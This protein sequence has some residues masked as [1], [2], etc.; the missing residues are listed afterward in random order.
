M[1]Y[2]SLTVQADLV[3]KKIKKIKLQTNTITSFKS[4]QQ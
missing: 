2:K 3:I 4:S 1:P